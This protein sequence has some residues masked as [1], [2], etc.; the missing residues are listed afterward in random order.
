ML[1]SEETPHEVADN[2][3]GFDEKYLDRFRK[4]R[5]RSG[6]WSFVFP[7]VTH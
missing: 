7:G 3:T 6:I 2:G 5:K 1:L 4:P